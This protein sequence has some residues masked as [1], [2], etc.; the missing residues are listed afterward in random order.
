MCVDAGEEQTK[1]VATAQSRRR[2][3][4]AEFPWDGCPGR[5]SLSS[6]RCHG[7]TTLL[8]VR[9]DERKGSAKRRTRRTHRRPLGPLLEGV[10]KESA[11]ASHSRPFLLVTDALTPLPRPF[12]IR[13]LLP[14]SREPPP[15]PGRAQP[16]PC[17]PGIRCVVPRAN[18][19][20][21]FIGEQ[22]R[23]G[24]SWPTVYCATISPNFREPRFE[25]GRRLQFPLPKGAAFQT[26]S[27]LSM[28]RWLPARQ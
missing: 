15:R 7:P 26:S 17:R 11:A 28:A 2:I 14:L 6:T 21:M 25:S 9:I 1:Q 27:C 3:T 4:P 8:A 23:Q 20:P 13:L 5:G 16:P 22:R 10:C 18:T 24:A 12:C 19:S